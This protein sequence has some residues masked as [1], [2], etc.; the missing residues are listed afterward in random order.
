MYGT[1]YM[2]G[3]AVKEKGKTANRALGDAVAG[4][5][6]AD[7]MRFAYSRAAVYSDNGPL[8]QEM[9]GAPLAFKKTAK[10]TATDGRRRQQA[11]G[12]RQAIPGEKPR[13]GCDRGLQSRA[14]RSA[15][16]PG[17]HAGIRR[18]V[19]ACGSAGP[20]LPLLRIAVRHAGRPARRE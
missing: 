10:A 1:I 18:S 12:S 6:S 19:R 3:G 5:H 16:A 2:P 20:R 11:S 17:S 4:Y 15:A 13:R 7:W 14:R 8:A 9:R